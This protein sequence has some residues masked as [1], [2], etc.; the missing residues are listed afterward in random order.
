MCS[1]EAKIFYED[2]ISVHEKLVEN[3]NKLITTYSGYS[4]MNHPD[5]AK[6]MRET[7]LKTTNLKIKL[8]KIISSFESKSSAEAQVGNQ[9]YPAKQ[10]ETEKNVDLQIRKQRSLIRR[11][12]SIKIDDDICAIKAEILNSHLS[13]LDDSFNL[14]QIQIEVNIDS[15]TKFE[16]QLKIATEIQR[17]VI[18]LQTTLKKIMQPIVST[19]STKSSISMDRSIQPTQTDHDTRVNLDSLFQK[20][21]SLI[22]Q[23]S[24]FIEP[25]EDLSPEKAKV[26]YRHLN[27]LYESFNSN[28]T[29]I[30]SRVSGAILDS[31]LEISEQIQNKMIELQVKF[32]NFLAPMKRSTSTQ[33]EVLQSEQIKSS[34][35][36]SSLRSIELKLTNHM[37]FLESRSS[38]DEAESNINDIDIHLEENL[39]ISK[40]IENRIIHLQGTLNRFV[41]ANKHHE[42]NSLDKLDKILE[43][44]ERFEQNYKTKTLPSLAKSESDLRAME[45]K[46]SELITTCEDLPDMCLDGHD[47]MENTSKICSSLDDYLN[48]SKDIQTKMRNFLAADKIHTAILNDIQTKVA[49][50]IALQKPSE[51]KQI[52]IPSTWTYPS[53]TSLYPNKYWPERP[54][55]G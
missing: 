2:L 30:E 37:D 18:D 26:M 1:A 39:E 51:P 55:Q 11:I 54:H 29:G 49:Q 24:S 23:M 43:F 7:H 38:R 48:I 32:E 17:K 12:E 45:L 14:N 20:R 8:A 53:R 10:S 41:D 52:G 4:S 6:E 46:L 25:G 33:S 42:K 5:F 3:E 21:E 13:Q 9:S 35:F 50:S 44:N 22:K 15:D 34:E 27:S 40:N 28:Q 16:N 47:T 19:S 36:E 31:Q